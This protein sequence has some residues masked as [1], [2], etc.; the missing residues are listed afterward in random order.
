[1]SVELDDVVEAF[2]TIQDLMTFLRDPEDVKI[3]NR[4]I[5]SLVMAI[6][7]IELRLN[8]LEDQIKRSAC[9]TRQRDAPSI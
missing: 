8:L 4:A 6:G 3:V 2:A 9:I 7:A 1:M 5:D